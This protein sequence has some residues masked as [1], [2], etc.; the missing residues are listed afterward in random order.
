MTDDDDSGTGGL[1]VG[2]DVGENA[3]AAL[4]I[5]T[6]CGLVENEDGGTHGNDTG[7]SDTTLLPAGKF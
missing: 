6:G 5:E 7:N 4:G 3:A 1:A 2:R